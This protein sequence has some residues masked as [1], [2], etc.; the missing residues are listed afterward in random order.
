MCGAPVA[1]PT[2]STGSL[3]NWVSALWANSVAASPAW[4][5][6]SL[7]ADHLSLHFRSFF[8]HP[9]GCHVPT[10]H[11]IDGT[12]WCARVCAH[13][14][15]LVSPGFFVVEPSHRSLLAL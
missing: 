10:W 2:N 7:D 1:R 15:G 8:A 13:H 6:R 12:A 11:R 4:A 5:A 9:I 14:G 3:V